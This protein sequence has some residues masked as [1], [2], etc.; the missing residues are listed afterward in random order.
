MMNNMPPQ[1][2]FILVSGF[3]D[4][5]NTI[6]S[7][8]IFSFLKQHFCFNS[9]FSL[10]LAFLLDEVFSSEEITNLNFLLI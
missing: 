2:E 3:F 10:G 8:N 6:F 5:K 9:L 4:L 1:S 7:P